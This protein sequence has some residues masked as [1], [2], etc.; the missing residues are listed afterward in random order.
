MAELAGLLAPV[1]GAA[2]VL[3][4]RRR[5]AGAFSWALAAALVALAGSLVGAVTSRVMWLGGADEV[6]EHMELGAGIRNVLLAL[7]WLLLMV[8]AFRRPQGRTRAGS[9]P[10]TSGQARR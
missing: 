4:Y 8:A 9:Q 6:T 5:L 1:A 7:A 3:Y 10:R 2:M